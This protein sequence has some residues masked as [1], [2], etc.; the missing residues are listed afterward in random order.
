M[1]ALASAIAVSAALAFIAAGCGGGASPEEKWAGSVCT[2]IG[3]WKSEV[4][5]ATDDISAEV[6]SPDT[7]TVAA[8]DSAV[9]SAV[10]ATSQLATELKALG[11][12]DTESG[13]QAKQEVD[14]FASQL[15]RTV[16]QVKQTVAS[17]PE[18]ASLTQTLQK[19]GPL[20]PTLESL[21]TSA[22]STVSTLKASGSKLKEGF[23]KADSCEQFQ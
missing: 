4:K 8:I 19:L 22:S 17:L 14:S 21:A 3:D 10:D 9:R 1:R 11:P 18:G 16:N 2:D 6:Q 13:A 12:P 7:G 5:K 20:A 23:D 15:E